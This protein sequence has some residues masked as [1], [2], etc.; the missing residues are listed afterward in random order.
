[1]FPCQKR[2]EDVGGMRAKER[3]NTRSGTLPAAFAIIFI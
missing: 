2:E 1:M 3:Y